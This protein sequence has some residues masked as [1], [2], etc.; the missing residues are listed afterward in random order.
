MR[1]WIMLFVGIG[2]VLPV[3]AHSI[4]AVVNDE[5]ISS[6]DVE[7]R[8]KLIQMMQPAASDIKGLEKEALDQLISDM[9]KIQEAT[10][11][12][13]S[14]SDADIDGAVLRLEEQNNLPA[15]ALKTE[16]AKNGIGLNALKKQLTADL[17]WLSI[18]RQHKDEIPDIQEQTVQER[19]AQMKQKLATEGFAVA[20]I[21]VK[22]KEVA[23]SIVQEIQKG[24]LFD[25]VAQKQSIADSAAK[26]GLV[27]WI[28]ENRYPENVMNVLRS[29]RQNELS[30]PIETDKGYYILALLE[31]KPATPEKIKLWELAQLA[32]LPTQ[33]LDVLPKLT[34]LSDCGVFTEWGNTYALPESVKH[35]FVNTYQLPPELFELLEHKNLNTLVGPVSMGQAD[36]FFMKCREEEKNLL[37]DSEVVRSQL[38][39]EQMMLLTE[40][41]MR[42]IKR[43][44]VI[45]YKD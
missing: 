5:P 12:K 23:D 30:R 15:G 18:L 25:E 1:F 24:A 2:W 29:M 14:V 28:E 37:P 9:L 13:V 43:Y 27:G 8:V 17:M 40:R 35:G 45:E 22:D 20:E 39:M 10:K 7:Q 32:V 41:L 44:A 21:L 38:E 42:Q 33:T 4:V 34:A 19:M 36:L 6:Y 11:N 3:F 16:L 31:Y 26:G